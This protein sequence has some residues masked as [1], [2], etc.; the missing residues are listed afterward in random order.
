MLFSD[1]N[2]NIGYELILALGAFLLSMF[3]TPIYTNFAY[4]HKL[5]KKQKSVAI[6]GEELTV[7]NKLHAAKIKRHF[8]TM[9]G[10][11][12][13][14]SVPTV[15][16]ACNCL[17]REQ[18][19]LPLAAFIGGGLIGFIDDLMN[20]Y[21]K[22]AVAGLRAPVKFAMISALGLFLGWFFAVK[23]GWTA[24]NVPFYGT[25]DIG[26][27][28]MILL[29]AFS[30][31]ATGNAVNISDGMDG[32]AGGLAMMAYGSYG[33][34]ALLQEQWYLAGFCIVVVGTL[35]AY[36]WF[37]VYPARFMMGDTGSFALGAGLGAVAVL[38]KSFL[39]LPVIG[40]LFV[41]EAGSSLIQII[42]KKFFH[43]KIFLSAPLHHHLQAKGWEESKVVMRFWI[44][45]GITAMLGVFL[46]MGGGIIR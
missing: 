34:I 15:I 39:L 33:V 41:V 21:G 6:T 23:L 2:K 3:L 13:L 22:N 28:G 12:M 24:L 29:F 14:V 19:W 17:T 7:M 36:T 35:L 26:V 46:A 32:L 9:A 18:T 1:I 10:V 16:I 31:V 42:S 45:G 44:I 37:N 11:I 4:K 20:L 30:V 27:V 40:F 5:W 25:L 8:P 43:R 38:T